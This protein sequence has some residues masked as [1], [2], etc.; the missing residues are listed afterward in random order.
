MAWVEGGAVG[1]RSSREGVCVVVV[2]PKCPC[3]SCSYQ[4]DITMLMICDG[5]KNWMSELALGQQMMVWHRC[6]S[7][8]MTNLLCPFSSFT[9]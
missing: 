5:P 7:Y 6:V 3:L 1:Q 8:D 2:R 4:N 9:L